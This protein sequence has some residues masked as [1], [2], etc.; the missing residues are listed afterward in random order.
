LEIDIEKRGIHRNPALKYT[1]RQGQEY[2]GL[3]YEEAS[4]WKTEIVLNYHYFVFLSLLLNSGLTS[5]AS[6][7]RLSQSQR[8][9]C[10]NFMNSLVVASALLFCG[11]AF[12]Q[13]KAASPAYHVGKLALI[14]PHHAYDW[15]GHYASANGSVNVYCDSTTYETN[16]TDSPASAWY[17][18]ELEGESTAPH[19]QHTLT[20]VA[21][22]VESKQV[23][24]HRDLFGGIDENYDPLAHG[25]EQL[26]KM[27]ADKPL[28]ERTKPGA[29]V[30]ELTFEYRIATVRPKNPTYGEAGKDIEVYCVPFRL[31]LGKGKRESE[32]SGETCYALK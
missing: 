19:I 8:G 21:V 26:N 30:T 23:K 5:S 4:D 29:S 10:G 12:A 14:T 25:K 2:R 1:Y 7:I 32:K 17:K 22:F 6:A 15:Q 27:E 16:C 28:S 13:E 3:F 11:S 24:L 9:R 20:P 18:V 31:K